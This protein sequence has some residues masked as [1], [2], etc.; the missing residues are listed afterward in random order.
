MKKIVAGRTK[1][2][3]AARSF[4]KSSVWATRFQMEAFEEGALDSGLGGV[5]IFSPRPDYGRDGGE[6]NSCLCIAQEL[7]YSCV[8][9]RH[10]YHKC[11]VGLQNRGGPYLRNM[12]GR[13]KDSN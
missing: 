6:R 2:F 8:T 11:G 13:L 1:A 7:P 9:E 10:L 3:L 12:N 4:L 5:G